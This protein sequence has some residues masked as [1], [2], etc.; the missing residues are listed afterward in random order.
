METH[1]H[2]WIHTHKSHPP[3]P[4]AHEQGWAMAN[5][6]L[7][8]STFSRYRSAQGPERALCKALSDWE[9]TQ[10][11]E[12]CPLTSS[13][14]FTWFSES[15]AF[16]EGR[17]P[18]PNDRLT[19]LDQSLRKWTRCIFVLCCKSSSY[20]NLITFWAVQTFTNQSWGGHSCWHFI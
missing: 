4:S 9:S 10:S 18:A 6:P 17:F 16:P 8:L 3:P 7:P 19:Y 15:I 14:G 20:G 13:I 12:M 1:K 11:P 2:T 5:G